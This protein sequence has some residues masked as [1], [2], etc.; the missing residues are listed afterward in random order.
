MRSE[1]DAVMGVTT[2]ASVTPSLPMKMKERCKRTTMIAQ[3]I[4]VKSAFTLLS[5]TVGAN[6][7]RSLFAPGV[8]RTI[9]LP[10]I[11]G[12]M[13]MVANGSVRNILRRNGFKTER[14]RKPISYVMALKNPLFVKEV[15]VDATTVGN[16]D[17]FE[18]TA[19]TRTSQQNPSRREMRISRSITAK[20][21]DQLSS[22]Y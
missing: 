9:T 3:T 22:S 8:I 19:P 5:S 4:Q 6:K 11:V 13:T 21:T 20:T 15:N 17:T 18:P 16:W 14:R 7:R 1:A 12:S 2:V 10:K